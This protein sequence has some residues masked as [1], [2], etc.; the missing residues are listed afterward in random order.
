[1]TEKAILIKPD[2]RITPASGCIPKHAIAFTFQPEAL[3]L[4][5][6]LDKV[7]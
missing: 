2:S 7:V 6:K 5:H 3:R 4:A 1:M